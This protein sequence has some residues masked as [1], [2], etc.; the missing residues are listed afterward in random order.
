M[1]LFS[2]GPDFL[3]GILG[4]QNSDGVLNK[5]KKDNTDYKG[6]DYYENRYGQQIGDDGYLKS[7]PVT[8]VFYDTDGDGIDDRFQSGPGKPK[9]GSN[10]NASPIFGGG[11]PPPGS[12]GGDNPNSPANRRRPISY[13]VYDSPEAYQEQFGNLD[14]YDPERS[15][16]AD[17]VPSNMGDS[18]TL[19]GKTYGD[20]APDIFETGYDLYDMAPTTGKLVTGVLDKFLPE[21][22]K[23]LSVDDFL[24]ESVK[25]TY[26]KYIDPIDKYIANALGFTPEEGPYDNSEAAAALS[27]L[28]PTS[29]EANQAAAI[30]NSL[31]NLAYKDEIQ[32][33]ALNDPD[34]AN[35]IAS[36]GSDLSISDYNQALED[37]A[38]TSGISLT[39][40]N[41]LAAY[42]AATATN[43]QGN[44][45][46]EQNAINNA[47]ASG[48]GIG[49][50]YN[51]DT[52]NYK[53]LVTYGGYNPGTGETTPVGIVGTGY[54]PNIQNE[55]YQNFF[56][57]NQTQPTQPSGDG[58]QNDGP[59]PGVSGA[60]TDGTGG[61][62]S[63]Y[64]G[65]NSGNNNNSGGGG[66][67]QGGANPSGKGKYGGR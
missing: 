41:P 24:P 64:G 32:G 49:F 46:S 9:A 7:G 56:N 37:A 50:G 20:V 17:F 52:G 30:E 51:E 18:T 2:T 23:D 63:Q 54:N 39:T 55:N 58:P 4:A 53:G 43:E 25:T 36:F 59:G 14:F 16:Y 45:Q 12:G 1:A 15:L 29:Y 34:L 38:L 3:T 26:D 6:L 11:N 8:T 42:Q 40:S 13:G 27:L 19:F 66:G 60:G 5:F 57:Q 67:F 22:V 21:S 10:P 47:V 35:A 44:T 62:D 61:P 31:A 28:G 48:D 33:L 65:N